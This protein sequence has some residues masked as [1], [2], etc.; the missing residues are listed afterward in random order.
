MYLHSLCYCNIQYISTTVAN[1]QPL[2][3]RVKS[4]IGQLIHLFRVSQ[5]DSRLAWQGFQDL[6]RKRSP[7]CDDDVLR[8]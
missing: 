8:E 2:S 1:R 6:V 3:D 7:G 4:K 5:R